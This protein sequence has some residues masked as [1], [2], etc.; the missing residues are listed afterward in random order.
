MPLRSILSPGW[1]P[2][3]VSPLASAAERNL[4]V[5]A[6]PPPSITFT[7]LPAVIVSAA[8]PP[9]KFSTPQITSLPLPEEET[10]PRSMSPVP[11]SAVME[12]DTADMS[13]VSMPGVAVVGVVAVSRCGHDEVLAA[14]CEDR[15]VAGARRDEVVAFARE[16]PVGAC[17][18]EDHVGSVATE[19]VVVAGAGHDRVAT[20]IALQEVVAFGAGDHVIAGVAHDRVVASETA[21]GVV[22]S[23]ADQA[24]RLRRAEL[25][26]AP[27]D[28]RR[29][30]RWRGGRRRLRRCRRHPRRCRRHHRS[31][32]RHPRRCRR[33]HRSCRRHPRRCRRRRVVVS[34]SLPVV[35]SSSLTSK[36]CSGRSVMPVFRATMS[37]NS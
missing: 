37:A 1:K 22:P 32:R 21:Q 7:A 24:V 13:R 29:R 26:L 18:A 36:R 35:L 11:R 14:S 20:G 34:S 30:R 31:C 15:I 6:P 25:D 8:E 10:L 12:A 17:V 19:H 27:Y 5:S 23:G 2:T 16:D 4:N 28:R 3:I 33:H 9:T